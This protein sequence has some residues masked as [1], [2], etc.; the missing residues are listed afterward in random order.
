MRQDYQQWT[1]QV[2]E[3]HFDI[4]S[5]FPAIEKPLKATQPYTYSF[6]ETTFSR[7]LHRL[8]LER[9]FRNLTSPDIVSR[10]VLCS[11]VLLG[12]CYTGQH[13]LRI[14]AVP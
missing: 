1:V 6:Q 8:C 3:T 2:P 13:Q 4:D 5:I 10:N 7:R 9:A 11:E 12:Q 14:V